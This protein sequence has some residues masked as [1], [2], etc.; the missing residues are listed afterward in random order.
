MVVSVSDTGVGIP[1]D[2]LEQIFNSFFTTKAKGT[3]MGLSISRT[4]VEAHGGRLWAAPNAPTTSSQQE[5][6]SSPPLKGFAPSRS[7]RRLAPL[8]RGYAVVALGSGCHDAPPRRRGGDWEQ[9]HDR[10]SAS[11]PDPAH[12]RRGVIPWV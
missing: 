8:R 1:V 9:R 4:I 10:V 5:N 3:G 2:K 12:R 11:K 7:R 6:H